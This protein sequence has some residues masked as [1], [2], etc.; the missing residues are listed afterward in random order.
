MPDSIIG[1]TGATRY[2]SNFYEDAEPI[3]YGSLTFRTGEHMYQALKC[4]DYE[5]ALMISRCATPG[6]AKRAGQQ[7]KLREDWEE[8]KDDAMRLTVG[9]KFLADPT[10]RQWLINTKDMHITEGNT[11]HD[12]YWGVC[13]CAACSGKV[14]LN[15]L[16][17]LLMEL[18]SDLQKWT[19]AKL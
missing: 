19:Q 2:L 12:N 10:I 11:W 5:D 1:F 16:G 8:V 18:R 4:A 9:R 7:I 13:Y 15:K 14:Q 6:Q 3:S 17:K